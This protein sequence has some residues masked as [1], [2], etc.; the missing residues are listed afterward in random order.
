MRVFQ[1]FAML[2]LLSQGRGS[3]IESYPLFGYDLHDYDELFAEKLESAAKDLDRGGRHAAVG[4]A[5]WHVGAAT[6][7]RDHQRKEHKTRIFRINADLK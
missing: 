5:G 1:D 7:N 6:G 3:F 2:D 4:G